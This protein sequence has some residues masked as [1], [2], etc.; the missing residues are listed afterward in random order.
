MTEDE[1]REWIAVRWSA[2]QLALLDRFAGLLVEE[3]QRQNLV[4]AS[5]LP[6]L[7]S[8]HITDSAQLAL[9]APPDATSWCDIGSGPGLPG[10]VVAI[11]RDGPMWLVEPRA[12]RVAFL[13]AA[14][15]E[16]GLQGRVT[17]IGAKAERFRPVRPI[18][19]V[20]ARAVAAF[21]ELLAMCEHFTSAATRYILPKGQRGAD[22]L[23][24]VTI[25]WHGKFHVEQSVTEPASTIIIADGVTRRCSAS[26]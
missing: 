15:Q 6:F 25:G 18:D 12:R 17:V 13:D 11:L 2:D 8:R 1:A 3:N 5:T 10:I 16:L 26:R 14:V 23:A 7:W 19:I 20:S 22:E 9:F 21:P 24:S 4:A